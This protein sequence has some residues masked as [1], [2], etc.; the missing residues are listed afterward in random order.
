MLPTIL[1]ILGM[2]YNPNFYYGDTIFIDV[3]NVFQ[4]NIS[5]CP[6]FTDE[7]LLANNVIAWLGEEVSKEKENT[8]KQA[9]LDT[10]YRIESIKSIYEYPEILDMYKRSLYK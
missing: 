7:F 8:F 2:E 3:I 5:G 4:S 9:A 10:F 1:D 6:Y